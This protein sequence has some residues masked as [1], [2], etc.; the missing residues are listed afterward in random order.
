METSWIPPIE[1]TRLMQIRRQQ[2]NT[3]NGAQNVADSGKLL[4]CGIER[5]LR[6]GEKLTCI[7]YLRPCKTAE[8]RDQQEPT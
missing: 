1:T 6:H 7:A 2:Q 4:P 3:K 5:N 8:R